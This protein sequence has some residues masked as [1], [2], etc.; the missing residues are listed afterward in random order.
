[1][2][3]QLEG[4]RKTIGI[5]DVF[6]ILIVA[7]ILYRVYKMLENTRAITLTRGLLILLLL[8]II[9]SWLELHVINWLLQKIVT[10]L[11]VALPIVFQPELRRALEHIGEGGFFKRSMLLNYEEACSLVSELDKAVTK[12]SSTKTGAL[13]V[14]ER[15]M[16][17]NDICASGIK[18]DGIVSA[19]FL[20]NVFIPNTPLHDGAAIIRG[21]RLIAAGCLLPLTDDRS[22]STELGTRHRAAIGL[23]EQCDAVV[24]IVSEETGTISVAEAGRI[25]RHLDSEQLKQYLM[26]IFSPRKTTLK[27]AVLKWRQKK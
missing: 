26:P 15:N 18:I 16:G 5:L 8:A 27:E 14:L 10:L 6:D 23:S 12:L 3:I 22:L 11:F 24:V 21:N 13:I 2:L 19:E 17:L 4:L 7:F 1:M 25:Y 9:T 20:L